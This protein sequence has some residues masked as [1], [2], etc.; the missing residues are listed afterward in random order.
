M[1]DRESFVA[2]VEAIRNEGHSFSRYGKR[3]RPLRSVAVAL[4]A[5]TCRSETTYL[6]VARDERHP[7]LKTMSKVLQQI[8]VR[9]SE[10]GVIAAVLITSALL[11]TFVI[12]THNAEGFA[13]VAL[14]L[15]AAVFALLTPTTPPFDWLRP[16]DLVRH[17][18]SFLPTVLGRSPPA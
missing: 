4:P 18:E 6:K 10:I 8:W 16:E 7:K 2:V 3:R 13:K 12:T 9:R 1:T 17:R 14:A 5:E 15:P 11:L